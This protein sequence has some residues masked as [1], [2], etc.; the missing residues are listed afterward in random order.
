MTPRSMIA[1]HLSLCASMT[2]QARA[3]ARAGR[4]E[5]SDKCALAAEHWHSMAWLNAIART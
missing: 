1:A 5:A 4:A 3:H 2:L